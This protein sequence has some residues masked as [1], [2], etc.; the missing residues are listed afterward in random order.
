[1]GRRR[2]QHRR[3]GLHR[4]QPRGGDGTWPQANRPTPA[5][6]TALRNRT[7]RYNVDGRTSTTVD[8]CSRRKVDEKGSMHASYTKPP[9]PPRDFICPFCKAGAR[10]K[11]ARREKL[12]RCPGA[13]FSSCPRASS[14]RSPARRCPPSTVPAAAVPDITDSSS[15]QLKEVKPKAEGGGVAAPPK[16]GRR[17]K[18]GRQIRGSPRPVR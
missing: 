13:L 9:C 4:R 14:S 16:K 5:R 10:S 12:R 6:V 17:R 2:R 7:K 15:A 18:Y 3:S 11:A 1:M 8:G